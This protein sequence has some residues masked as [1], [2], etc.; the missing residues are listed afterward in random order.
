M[1][2]R[3]TREQFLLQIEFV[4]DFRSRKAIEYPDDKRN[5]YSSEALK[6]LY[7]YVINI[8]KDHCVFDLVYNMDER[9][10]E[11]FNNR[12]SRYGFGNWK[13]N[14]EEFIQMEVMLKIYKTNMS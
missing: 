4:V 14:P 8:P 1:K 5:L 13:E 6:E 9:E 11:E 7:K 3:E 2:T 10:R 12:L